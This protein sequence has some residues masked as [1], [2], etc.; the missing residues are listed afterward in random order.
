MK[1]TFKET[2]LGQW[3][4]I[5]CAHLV[6][7]IIAAIPSPAGNV[8]AIVKKFITGGAGNSPI[9]QTS[10]DDFSANELEFAKEFDCTQIILEK[11]ITSRNVT[12]TLSGDFLSKNI[13]PMSL[14]FL[15]F[16]YFLTVILNFCGVTLSAP[17]V[18]MEE[19]LLLL[20]FAFYFGGRTYEKI[21]NAD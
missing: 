5:H 13:R 14:I 6:D 21:K 11:E 20:S 2:L 1:K 9:T 8:V 7:N 10:I 18:G 3:C 19:K 17:V 4:Q 15:L 12:D 16:C